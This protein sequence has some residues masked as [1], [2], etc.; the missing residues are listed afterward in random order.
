MALDMAKEIF[1]AA[2]E[3]KKVTKGNFGLPLTANI[4]KYGN[5]P[6]SISE[7]LSMSAEDHEVWLNLNRQDMITGYVDSY[8]K[9]KMNV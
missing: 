3:V 8:K 5:C 2:K 7:I 9:R 1:L 6:K 4:A